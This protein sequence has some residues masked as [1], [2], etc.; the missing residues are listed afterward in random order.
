MSSF[1]VKAPLRNAVIT[2]DFTFNSASD[3]HKYLTTMFQ[4]DEQKH[5]YLLE[6]AFI[7]GNKNDDVLN[8]K[9]CQNVHMICFNPDGHFA[10]KTNICSCEKCVT[11]D[12]LNCNQEKGV[13]FNS[14]YTESESES[15]S[16]DETELIP[17]VA[18]GYEDYELRANNIIEIVKK[19]TII[20]LYSPRSSIELFYLCKVLDVSIAQ[21]QLV[22]KFNDVI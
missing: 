21:N 6:K 2:K 15:E 13:S 22:D 10:T 4:H 5:H 16:D 9:G 11:G 14:Q 20:A 19:N 17:Q 7:N 3:I 1:G 18:E 12:F 8:I